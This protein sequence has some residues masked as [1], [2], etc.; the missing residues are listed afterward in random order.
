M[1]KLKEGIPE[2]EVPSLE[3]LYIDSIPLANINDFQA[4]A[5]NVKLSGLSDFKITFMHVN[6][7]EQKIDVEI[8]FPKI[9]LDSDYDVKAK[10]I[11][12]INEKGPIKCATSKYHHVCAF[13]T[14][15]SYYYTTDSN[16]IVCNSP[17]LFYIALSLNTNLLFENGTSISR[18]SFLFCIFLRREIVS[19]FTKH[20]SIGNTFNIN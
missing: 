17:I 5:T 18:R 19:L 14:N 7:K 10:I 8:L 15:I 2:L 13:I 9:L 4:I 20:S 3:P 1:P 11:V 16:V 12:P 6:L